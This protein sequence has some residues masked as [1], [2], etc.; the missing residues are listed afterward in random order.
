MLQNSFWSSNHSSQ[1]Q[2][3]EM[4]ENMNEKNVKEVL[5]K[6]PQNCLLLAWNVLGVKMANK[7]VVKDINEKEITMDM[8]IKKSLA[9]SETY[10]KTVKVPL[11][12]KNGRALHEHVATLIQKSSGGFWP[13]GPVGALTVL[14]WIMAVS[15]SY[16]ATLPDAIKGNSVFI[17]FRTASLLLLRSEQVAFYVLGFMVGTH[18]IEGICVI[19][20]VR[21]YVKS[22]GA[23]LSWILLTLLLGFPVTDRAFTLYR[24][25]RKGHKQQ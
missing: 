15:V 4:T 11:N 12:M 3:F 22:V 16:A 2:L 8:E 19:I 7:A 24:A 23:M 9:S 13:Q 17:L 21:R 25:G 14:M 10:P 5:N 1:S 6:Q 20:F 18:I